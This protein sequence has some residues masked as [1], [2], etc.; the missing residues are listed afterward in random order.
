MAKR[1][2]PVDKTPIDPLFA[3]PYG[4][5]DQFVFSRESTDVEEEVSEYT[6]GSMADSWVEFD[7]E[8]N[9]IE[10]DDGYDDENA[11]ELDTPDNFT[12]VSQ[13]LRRAPGG[14]QVVDIV[15][16]AED[17]VGAVNYEIQVTKV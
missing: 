6:D 1:S 10:Y 15:L 17:V 13:T 2:T 12:I 5:E 8:G 16:Q 3:V 4:A 9:V 14:Q 11:I 7:D